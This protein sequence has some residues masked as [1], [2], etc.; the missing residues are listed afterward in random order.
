[1]FVFLW[2][3]GCAANR[4]GPAPRQADSPVPAGLS[5]FRKFCTG[6]SGYQK[7]RRFTMENRQ[8]TAAGGNQSTDHATHKAKWYD[9]VNLVPLAMRWVMCLQ[10]CAFAP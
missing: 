7:S 9:I 8:S 5:D 2:R 6:L 10:T 1:M 3:C 4:I